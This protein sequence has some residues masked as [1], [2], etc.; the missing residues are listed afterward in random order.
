MP[1]QI[2]CLWWYVQIR[3]RCGKSGTIDLDRDSSDSF[4][5][6]FCRSGRC[7]TS[8]WGKPRKLAGRKIHLNESDKRIMTLAGMCAAFA[9]LL[10]RRWQQHC[11]R[12]RLSV[13][14]IMYYAALVPCM[15]SA[16]IG[17]RISIF[18]GVRTLTAPYPVAEVPDF[19]GIAWGKAILLAIVLHL[20]ERCSR[21]ML[22]IFEKQLKKWFSE[23]YLRVFI[24]GVT[25]CTSME[26]YGNRYLPGTWWSTIAQSFAELRNCGYFLL[27]ILFTCITL[28]SGF[29]A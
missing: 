18:M 6:R 29:K 24:G 10:E 5:W 21:V 14:G 27:K 22:H 28:C 23:S 9:A 8:V 25:C 3:I 16:F 4:V 17:E 2:W 26:D 13:V 12:W 19:Y 7:G 1:E 11:S 15:F 20:S